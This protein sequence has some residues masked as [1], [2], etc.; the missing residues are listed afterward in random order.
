[1]VSQEPAKLS[2][3][4]CG[5]WVRIPVPPPLVSSMDRGRVDTESK[6]ITSITIME[7]VYQL[8]R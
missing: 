5:V 1:M 4:L 6:R 3:A 7:T 8:V 2:T